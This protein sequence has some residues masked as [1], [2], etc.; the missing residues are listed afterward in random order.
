MIEEKP[1]I[2]VIGAKGMLGQE[3]GLVLDDAGLPWTGTDQEVDILSPALLAEKA[4]E[5]NPTVMVNCSAY[6]AVDRAEEDAETAY[7]VNRDGAANLAALGA[8]RDVPL[9]HISTDYVFPGTHPEPLA[10]E[11]PTGPTGVYGASKLAGEEAIRR[12]CPKHFIIRTAWLYGRFGAN[13]VYTMIK[14]MNKLDS[15][16]VVDDQQGIPHLDEGSRRGDSADPGRRYPRLRNLPLFRGGAVYLVR[17]RPGDL[18]PGPGGGIDHL[19]VQ[20]YSLYLRG[21]SHRRQAAGLLPV[22]EGEGE[23]GFS[24]CCA[25]VAGVA[26]VV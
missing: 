7:A 6:T 4:R 21:V 12:I 23:E 1:M 13:F 20:P 18:P 11:A 3:V 26:S 9:I 24:S 15:L 14:L 8:E 25:P 5:I 16:K 22:I 2:W 17:L 10:E 19:G